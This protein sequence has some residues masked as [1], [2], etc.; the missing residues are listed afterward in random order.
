MIGILPPTHEDEEETPPP[1]KKAKGL[2]AIL[3]RI[4]NKTALTSNQQA[5]KEI[6]TYCDLG[7]EDTSSDPLDW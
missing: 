4:P 7:L 5:K 6:A 3:E 1:V 2:A